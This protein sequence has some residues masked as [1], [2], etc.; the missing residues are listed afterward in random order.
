M[1]DFCSA[2]G[3]NKYPEHYSS[4]IKMQSHRCW[5]NHRHSRL[6]YKVYEAERILTP[7]RHLW[8]CF[9]IWRFRCPSGRTRSYGV[10]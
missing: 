3:A 8:P 6:L 10:I 9:N 1:K 2:I 4:R 5:T 7:R